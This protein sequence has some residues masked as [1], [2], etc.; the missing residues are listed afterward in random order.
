MKLKHTLSL[1]LVALLTPVFSVA[2]PIAV[3]GD[4][5]F[6]AA[7]GYL[8]IAPLVVGEVTAQV[9]YELPEGCPKNTVIPVAVPLAGDTQSADLDVILSG[10]YAVVAD[11]TTAKIH[12]TVDVSAC[13]FKKPEIH[14]CDGKATVNLDKGNLVIPCLYVDGVL[15]SIEMD[16]RGRSDNWLVDMNKVVPVQYPK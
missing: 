3:K 2:D 14:H 13:F 16:R 5:S 11:F 7:D 10:D 4:L 9:E 15:F 12:K 1:L 8:T 6:V